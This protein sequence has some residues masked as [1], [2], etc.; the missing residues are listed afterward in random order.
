MVF[1][2]QLGINLA[3]DMSDFHDFL[4]GDRADGFFEPAGY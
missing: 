2:N 3:A 4:M 1:L